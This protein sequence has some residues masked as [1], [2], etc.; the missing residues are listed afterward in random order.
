MTWKLWLDDDALNE[1]TPE[2]HAPG[3]Y[4]TALN[5]AQAIALVEKNGPP[6]LMDLDHDLG[7]LPNGQE[8][9]AMIFLKWLT[10]NHPDAQFEYEIH[11]KNPVGRANIKSY[12]DSWHRSRE[13]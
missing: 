3:G 13:I 2:R 6:F 10:N 7:L 4:S 5:S 11:S 9:T 1:F 8:D 12:I